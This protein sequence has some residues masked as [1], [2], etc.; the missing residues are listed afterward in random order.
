MVVSSIDTYTKLTNRIEYAL[1]LAD[2]QSE[3]ES[4]RLTHEE[5]FL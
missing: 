5:F 4:S 1:D 2:K 3:N